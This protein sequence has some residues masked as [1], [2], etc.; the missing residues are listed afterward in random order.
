MSTEEVSSTGSGWWREWMGDQNLSLL[1]SLLS[2]GIVIYVLEADLVNQNPALFWVL[3]IVDLLLV[4]WFIAEHARRLSLTEDRKAWW[5]TEGW[6][7][8]G[9]TPVIIAAL[10]PIQFI[11]LLRLV[12]LTRVYSSATNLL[13]LHE[14]SEYS[15][16]H[17]QIQHL[18]FVVI[19]LVGAGGFMAYI[20]EKPAHAE[21]AA[22]LGCNPSNIIHTIPEAM[23]WA[24][25]TA[26]TVGYG[27]FYP[28]T[29][30]GRVVS[31]LLMVL[32]V[33]VF[34]LL[35][36]TLS[37]LLWARGR[38]NGA[39]QGPEIDSQEVI[40]RLERLADM[41]RDGWLTATEFHDAK[42]SVLTSRMPGGIRAADIE[43]RAP[44]PKDERKERRAAARAGFTP[45]DGDDE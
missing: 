23:W 6:E 24:A 25:T 34:G 38:S 29:T 18:A 12:H 15:P 17:K 30:G 2:I 19:S 45:L 36:A 39:T 44:I 28:V 43:S 21:C 11:V 13:G 20:F 1:F 26:T 41:R 27:D 7:L 16:I 8:I 14:T 3:V 37:Q 32:G 10:P 40:S 31:V 5:R 35:A 22:Q 33:G 9:L 42:A 4:G